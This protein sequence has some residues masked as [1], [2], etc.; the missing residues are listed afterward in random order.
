MSK[1]LIKRREIYWVDLSDSNGRELKEL[2][3]CLVISNDRQNF[4][5]HL[6]LKK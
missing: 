1:Q 2:H 4:T 6:I 3:S 5:N